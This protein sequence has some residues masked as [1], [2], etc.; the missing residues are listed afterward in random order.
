MNRRSIITNLRDTREAAAAKMRMWGSRA[1]KARQEGR[2][3]DAK[4]CDDKVRDWASKARQLERTENS[5]DENP[6][7]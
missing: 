4:R 2:T 6:Q 3:A 5:Q 7:D 1:A